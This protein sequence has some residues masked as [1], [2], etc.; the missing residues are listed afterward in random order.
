WRSNCTGRTPARNG[1]V[2]PAGDERRRARPRCAFAWPRTDGRVYLAQPSSGCWI[3]PGGAELMLAP[4]DHKIRG[5]GEVLR[6]SLNCALKPDNSFSALSRSFSILL[7]MPVCTVLVVD[8]LPEVHE[9]IRAM[10]DGTEWRPERAATGEDALDR[11]KA[12]PYDV[13]LSDILMPG[14][15]G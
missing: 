5:S 8:D 6:G 9:L 10:L 7:Q 14:M 15:D 2:F 1:R 3:D 12:Q 13:V 4:P 11:L